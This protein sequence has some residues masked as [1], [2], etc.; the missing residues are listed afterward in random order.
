MR[1]TDSRFI[2]A[3]ADVYVKLEKWDDARR[4]YIKAYSVGDCEGNALFKLAKYQN[5][6]E[7]RKSS[8]W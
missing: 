8:I 1:P 3:L 6:Y 7:K 4:C 2:V 5:I